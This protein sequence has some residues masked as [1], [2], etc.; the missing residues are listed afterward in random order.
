MKNTE[1][2]NIEFKGLLEKFQSGKSNP[3]ELRQ[4]EEMFFDAE[5]SEGIK[6]AMLNE[7]R[8]F[9]TA[10]S[11][12]DTDYD[13][14]FQSI[15]KIISDHKSNTRSLNLRLNFMRI[16]A[17]IVMAF[18]FGGTLSYFIFNSDKTTSGSFCEVTA[19]LGSTSE[20]VLPDS[21]KVWL[22]AGSKIKYS[23]TYNQKNR[24]IYLEGEGYFIVAKNKEIPFI[25]DAYGFEVKAVGTEFNVKAYKSDP[26]VETTMVEGKVTLQHSTESILKGVYLT[27][28]Q[29]ATFYKKEESLTV[30]VIKK[31]QEKKEELNYIPEHRLVIAPRIDPKAIVSWKENRL[32]I[33]RE[34]L[35]TL[36]EILSRKYN[37][38]FEFKSED[39]KRISFSG[40]LEDETL[41]QVMNVIKISSP[42][43][44][45][46][47]GKTVIIEQNEA[48]MSEFKKLYKQK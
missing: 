43:D 19:P 6:S 25:V 4:L 37:F 1:F 27:P 22:N 32:I 33:E 41:Q 12:T 31:L 28:N 5:I 35:G 18:V 45:E 26:T 21:S 23:T 42:I 24:L 8:D 47:V 30:E 7:I 3:E 40:T 48:R 44:Y 10:G 46:I 34:Q 17:I 9:E 36:A 14:L 38:N 39:I 11:E 29:K 13:R 20:I 2:S 15:Q 16:A